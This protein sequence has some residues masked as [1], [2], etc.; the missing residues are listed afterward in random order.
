MDGPFWIILGS[1]LTLG[2]W[3]IWFVLSVESRFQKIEKTIGQKQLYDGGIEDSIAEII[4]TEYGFVG[5]A[6][7]GHSTAAAHNIV[8]LL[9]IS[10]VAKSC[11]SVLTPSKRLPAE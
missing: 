11:E 7:E 10:G 1:A 3:G 4:R 5:T 6:D 9:R 8:N 2:G